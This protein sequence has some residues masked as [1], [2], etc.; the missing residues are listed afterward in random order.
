MMNCRDYIFQL[1]SGQLNQAGS[2]DRFWAAQHRLI[3]RRCRAFSRNDQQLDAILD[4]YRAHLTRSSDD[5][6][7]GSR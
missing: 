1:T 2:L 6:P 4:S 3:C 7:S 5:P